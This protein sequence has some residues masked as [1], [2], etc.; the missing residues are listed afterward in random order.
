MEQTPERRWGAWAGCSALSWTTEDGRHLWGRNFDFNRVAEG[1]GVTYL[2][3]GTEYRTCG[4]AAPDCRRRSAYAAVGMGLLGLPESPVLYEGLNERGLMGGQLYYRQ[5]AHYPRAVRPGTIPLQPPLAVYHLLAQCATV[6]EVV[7]ALESEHTLVDRPLLGTVP[8]LHWCFSDR[9][10]ETVVVEP[11]AEGLRIYRNTLGV[12][13]NSPGYSWHLQNLL[14]YSGVRDLDRGALELE[15]T[16]LVQCFSGT[17]AQGLPGDW[18]SPSRFVRLAFLKR[19]AVR[20]R[21]EDEGVARMFR[22]L[23]SAAF[24]LGMVRVGEQEPVTELDKELSP[25]DYTAYTCVLCAESLRLYW[26]TYENQR[27]RWVSLDRLA[28]SGS[29]LQLSPDL[30][31][32]FREVSLPE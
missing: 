18:S 8:P 23:Q 26:T 9:T 30:A 19:Y 13:T 14:N 15:G 24:P 12:M 27:V 10:G 16:R 29:P 25:Y 21:Q 3:P 7:R 20:G 4:G 2:P 17:G 11:D 6:K 31:P 28:R 5:L 22:L 32:E 1:T